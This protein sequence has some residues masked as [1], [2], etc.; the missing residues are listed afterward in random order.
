MSLKFDEPMSSPE[1]N[2][3]VPGTDYNSSYTDTLLQ[4][5]K[6]SISFSAANNIFQRGWCIVTYAKKM[7]TDA[8]KLIINYMTKSYLF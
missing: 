1:G 3:C 5:W 6:S 8:T 7:S 4:H 2:C